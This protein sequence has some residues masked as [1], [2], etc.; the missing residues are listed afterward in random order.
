MCVIVAVGSDKKRP[1]EEQIN[2][3][4]N[5]NPDGAGIAWR[6]I[7]VDSEGNRRGKVVWHKGLTLPDIK[8]FILEVAKA[9]FVA[10]FRIKSVGDIHPQLTHPFPLTDVV[11]L[12]LTGEVDRPVLFHNGTWGQWRNES[13][14]LAA[15]AGY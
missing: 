5:T 7:E 1:N 3:M 8:K 13:M 6:E 9:P 11:E 10:H 4:W 15:Q 14:R 12:D 2:A